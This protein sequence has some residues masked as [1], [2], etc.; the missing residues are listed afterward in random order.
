L[1]ARAHRAELLAVQRALPAAVHGLAALGGRLA[2][3]RPAD[4]FAAAPARAAAVGL[5]ALRRPDGPFR[6]APGLEAPPA[7]A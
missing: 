3:A 1:A 5:A 4:G 6:A 7:A 2:R